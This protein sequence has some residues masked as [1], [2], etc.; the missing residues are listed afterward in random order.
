[1]KRAV[2]VSGSTLIEAVVAICMLTTAV[3]SLAGL[4]S[5]AVRTIALT[6]ERTVAAILAAQKLEELFV[7]ARPLSPSSPDAV[8]HDEAG[9]VEY[10][11]AAGV[12]V[13]SGAAAR[14]VVYVRR[15]A[16]SPLGADTALNVLHVAVSPCRYVA[17]SAGQCGDAAGT[18]RLATIRSSVTW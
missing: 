7:A 17:A 15:W 8:S 16:I 1:V 13:G 12:V 6:R 11:D 5:V 18:V 4:V 10:L 2:D 3:V 14:G 9:F